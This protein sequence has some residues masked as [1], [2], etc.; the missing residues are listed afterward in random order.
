MK[1]EMLLSFLCLVIA[2]SA[3]EC[4]SI[5]YPS[6]ERRETCVVE[7]LMPGPPLRESVKINRLAWPQ[8][9]FLF[10]TLPS[11]NNVDSD[12]YIEPICVE[13]DSPPCGTWE[14]S[15]DTQT[16]EGIFRC[17][18][19]KVWWSIH[20]S[21]LILKMGDTLSIQTGEFIPPDLAILYEEYYPA[22]S[23]TST[24]L[25]TP[26]SQPS[27]RICPPTIQHLYPVLNATAVVSSDCGDRTANVIMAVF[28]GFFTT[29]FLVISA[30]YCENRC[31]GPKVKCPYCDHY[32]D[33]L[34]NHLDLCERH[35]EKFEPIIIDQV[36]IIENIED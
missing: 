29:T 23:P 13:C 32:V 6:I 36:T 1:V 28:L 30:V 35:L 9:G 25:P 24:A 14:G 11:L 27:P 10:N 5:Y 3:A 20:F 17:P 31:K 34:K 2:V 8:S 16:C 19:D 15:C 33:S 12:G 4:G 22:P 7:N 26:L 21:N 18:P